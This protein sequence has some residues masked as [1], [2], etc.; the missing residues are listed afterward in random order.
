MLQAA[1]RVNS[2][3]MHL[4]T[5]QVKPIAYPKFQEIGPGSE[6]ETRYIWLLLSGGTQNKGE[7]KWKH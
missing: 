1:I 2:H 3:V 7:S 6:E 4:Q 5:F